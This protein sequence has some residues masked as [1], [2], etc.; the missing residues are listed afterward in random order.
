MPHKTLLERARRPVSVIVEQVRRLQIP[1]RDPRFW[2]I[3]TLVLAIGI[4]HVLLEHMRILVDGSEI[5][6]LSISIYLV[7]AVFAGLSFGVRG[8]LP[9]TIW[10]LVLSL[11]EISRHTSDTQFGIL[12]QFGIILVIANI[13]GVRVGRERAAAAAAARANTR[14]SRLNA[15]ASAVTHSLDLSNVLHDTLR[16]KIDRATRQVAWIRLLP[17]PNFAGVTAIDANQVEVP[18]GLTQLQDGLTLAACLTGQEQRDYLSGT[19]PHTAVVPLSSDGDVVGA[20][21]VT[22]LDRAIP[23]DEYQVLE[24][25]ASQ[26]SVALNNIRHHTSTR[27]ALAALSIANENLE[28]YIELATEAQEE[29]RKRLSRE[30]H[31][32][33]MQSLVLTLSQ[34]ES[35]TVSELP[36]ESRIRLVG[37]QGILTETLDNVRRYC[38]DLRPSLIDDLGLVD[39][40]DWLV[41]DLKA[42]QLI[43]V[44]L[45][46]RGERKRLGSRD[47]LLVF[48]IVQEALHN[49]ERHAHAERVQ[50][51]I[52]FSDSQLFVE[53]ADDGRGTVPVGRTGQHPAEYGLGLRGM[54]ERTKLLRGSLTIESK[55]GRGTRVV[56][57]VPLIDNLPDQVF[58]GIT[59]GNLVT[60]E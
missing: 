11:P 20:I 41:G 40:I 24:A 49:V 12:I 45:A 48:R 10:A 55:R 50:V 51:K 52:Q 29:E 14:L 56:L 7:P 33:T 46:V 3:Q 26:L 18:A 5:Y 27:D 36:E 4:S 44:D 21:G 57:F 22:Y 15:T 54:E 35:A 39:A 43:T 42:R 47:E 8:A 17:G 58:A 19:A 37:A 23:S 9:T 2:I 16:A 32:D 28:T 53:V 25:I 6:L 38:R 13:V 59:V 31:D 30:L 34:I 60:D 1:V